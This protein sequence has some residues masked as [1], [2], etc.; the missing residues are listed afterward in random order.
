M[1]SKFN[2]PILSL[3]LKCA[4]LKNMLSAVLLYILGV[5]IADYLGVNTDWNVIWF[6]LGLCLLLIVASAYLR[7]YFDILEDDTRSK[8]FRE[9]W[10]ESNLQSE[11]QL[12]PIA[13][14]QIALAALAAAAVLALLLFQREPLNRP[15][16]IFLVLI[17]F[18]SFIHGVPPLRVVYSGYGEITQAIM[19]A[20]LIPAF[21]FSL[22]YGDTH[23]LLGMVTFP[24]TFLHLAM[25]LAL[26]LPR[27]ADDVK[28]DRQTL[29][30]R[31]GWQR[32]MT[33]H[34][35]AILLAFVVLGLAAAF[36]LPWS[37]TWPGLLTLPVGIF[38][39]WQILQIG[40]GARPNWRLIRITAMSTLALTGYML[41]YALW[42][43]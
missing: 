33:L 3:I 37:L 43:G 41:A 24:L 14:L 16:Q 40:N 15:A 30:S 1:N 12:R 31:L 28:Y 38:Q 36:G 23:R 29:M 39:I 21:A 9:S 2:S 7:T 13:F 17:F 20:N 26:A 34:N 5:G 6:G 18:L 8:T 42:T 22:Q 10:V 32:G 11:V 35:I 27:Y 4:P 25:S 19:I